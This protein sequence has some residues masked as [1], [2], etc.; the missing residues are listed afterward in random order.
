MKKLY[1]IF[2]IIIS[3]SFIS[4]TGWIKLNTSPNR[5]LTLI[6]AAD[7]SIQEAHSVEWLSDEDYNLTHDAFIEAKAIV[8]RT[9]LIE[10]VHQLLLDLRIKLGDNNRAVP[11]IDIALKFFL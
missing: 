4:C 6:V 3:I 11:Y 8:S 7:W 2:I 1:I 9:N 10:P 5:L